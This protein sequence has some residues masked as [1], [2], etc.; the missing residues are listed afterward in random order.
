MNDEFMHQYY[1]EPR[2]EFVGALYER[3]SQ[4]SQPHFA[5]VIVKKLTFRNAAIAFAFLFF[6]AACVY[7]VTEKRWDR[8]G[9]IWVQVERT[10]KVEFIPPPEE[11]E[12]PGI[13]FEEPQCLTLEEAMEIL[14]FDFQVPTWA[15]EG[16]RFDD[17]ICGIDR[18]SDYA[19]LFWAGADQSS[20]IS[21]MISNQRGFNIATQK[22]EIGPA[23]IWGPVAPGS[24]K[25]VQVHGQPAVLVQGDWDLP[26]IV[27]EVPPGREVDANGQVEAKWDKKRGIQLHWLD[28]EI[29]YSLYG[30]TNVSSEDL[31]RMAESA[32]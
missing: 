17:R 23:A 1:E 15:P 20:G 2:A 9:E 3:I 4:E 14:R 7:A 11:S 24:Y 30:G 10:H 25:E 22:Y 31:L 8:V 12:E 27:A 28:G 16:F 13:Q 21:L 18:I 26:G 29:M 19:S 5:Q 6:V 32:Q